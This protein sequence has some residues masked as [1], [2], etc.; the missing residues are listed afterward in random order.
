MPEGDTLYRVATLLGP[1]LRGQTILDASSSP[2]EA[3]GET[4]APS[5]SNPSAPPTFAW[6]DR[7]GTWNDRTGLTI[8]AASLIGRRVTEVAPR[9]KHLLITLDDERVIHSHL[10]MTGSWHAYPRDEAWRKPARQASLA[11]WT[12]EHAAV[13]FLP[14][15]L[16][17]MSARQLQRDTHLQ[18]LGPDLMRP[19]DEL[20]SILPRLRVHNATPIG[21]AVM[22][23]TIAAGIGNVYKSE[24]LFLARLWPWT[25][26]GALSDTV[27][28]DYLQLTRQWMWRN[29][30]RGPRVTRWAADGRRHWVYGR[31]GQP[32]FECGQTI[33]VRRQ[34]DAGRTTYWCR[35][36]QAPGSEA[37]RSQSAQAGQ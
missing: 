32:C 36:C 20:R 13:L 31:G 30:G 19:A 12:A 25:P 2:A 28:L 26:V 7:T 17:L 21:E 4:P 5:P 24:T 27:L 10:G 9:G 37:P 18:R 3:A 11:L 6:S 14:K 22:N 8:D 15:Q 23:Q 33:E 1:V 34:G 35:R 16:A 29:R